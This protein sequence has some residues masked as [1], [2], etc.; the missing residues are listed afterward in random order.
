MKNCIFT[1]LLF[2]TVIFSAN[3]Q[4]VDNLEEYT[5]SNGVVYKVGDEIKLGRGSGNNGKFVY[6]TIGGWGGA[7][8]TPQDNGLPAGSTGLVVT[9]KKIRKYDSKR[10]K[11]VLFIVGGGNITNYNLDIESAI[12][13]CEIEKCKT[14]S[15][16]P[17]S[18]DDKFDKLKKLKE[19]YDGGAITE[20]EYTEQKKK[21][22][23]KEN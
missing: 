18:A 1:T 15:E 2:L 16:A 17:K 7:L 21:L 3:A 8:N 23:E 12:A 9:L 14:V 6:V 20:A 13:E 11:K 5:A 22:L 4:K 19:L 10:Y